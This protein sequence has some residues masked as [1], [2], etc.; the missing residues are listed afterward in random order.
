MTKMQVILID[1]EK[2]AIDYLEYQL[3]S[4]SD[5]KII[6]RYTKPFEGKQA[7]EQSDV[8]L[9]FLDIEIPDL[10]GIELANKILEKKPNLPIVFVTAYDDYAIEAFEL[11]AIDYIL[12]PVSTSR[13]SMT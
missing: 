2:L 3:K 5:F 10:N 12:K 8:D 6:G 1:D 11:N 13:L 4:V 7:I 9:V